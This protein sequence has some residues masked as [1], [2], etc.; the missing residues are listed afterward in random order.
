MLF[1][2]LSYQY[3]ESMLSYICQLLM[4]EGKNVDKNG[5]KKVA[6]KSLIVRYFIR[7]YIN[8]TTLTLTILFLF[9]YL[10]V[11]CLSYIFRLVHLHLLKS[12]FSNCVILRFL[13]NLF[14]L[15]SYF[16]CCVFVDILKRILTF[17]YL[18]K[19]KQLK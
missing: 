7:Y 17:D 2:R 3:F 5:I 12:I 8:F 10:L 18:Q 6:A 15:S 19:K 9:V 11:N 16:I 1:T 14:I 4:S 13:N